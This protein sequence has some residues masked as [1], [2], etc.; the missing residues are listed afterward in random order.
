M[1]LKNKMLYLWIILISAILLGC[2][3]GVLSE[4]NEFGVAQ[5]PNFGVG[6]GMSV[7]GGG[8]MPRQGVQTVVPTTVIPTQTPFLPTATATLQI[9]ATV[10]PTAFVVMATTPSGVKSAAGCDRNCGLNFCI[11]DASRAAN[12]IR[13]QMGIALIGD[14]FLPGTEPMIG[15]PHDHKSYCSR[16]AEWRPVSEVLPVGS[17]AWNAAGLI[18][19]EL[20]FSEDPYGEH[21]NGSGG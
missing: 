10:V 12:R 7:E 4:N 1:I 20:Q 6:G 3:A 21:D 18:K 16:E 11:S 9:T 13:R 8:V 14:K 5:D 19:Q 17:P 15:P 2:D